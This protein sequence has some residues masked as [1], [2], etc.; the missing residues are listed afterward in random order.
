[1]GT[2]KH[3]DCPSHPHLFEGITKYDVK[4]EQS[5]TPMGGYSGNNDNVLLEHFEQFLK[6]K[7][8]TFK[9]S[10]H[11]T[12]SAAKRKFGQ[13]IYLQSFQTSGWSKGMKMEYRMIYHLWPGYIATWRR[14]NKTSQCNKRTSNLKDDHLG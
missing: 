4:D 9:I 14:D 1:V 10:N 8:Q 12:L 11:P 3:I 13:D 7:I 5:T 2:I 6:I